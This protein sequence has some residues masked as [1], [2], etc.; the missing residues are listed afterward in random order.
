MKFRGYENP[1]TLGYS[2]KFAE[3]AFT[4]GEEYDVLEVLD[5]ND[6]VHDVRLID[7]NGQAHYEKR[8]YFDD[9]K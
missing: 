8:E 6:Q 5:Y 9:V 3:G 2:V 7:D 1:K 4:V